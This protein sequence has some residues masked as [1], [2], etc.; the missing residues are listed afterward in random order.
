MERAHVD[1]HKARAGLRSEPRHAAVLRIDRIAEAALAQLRQLSPVR[2]EGP[3]SSAADLRL[4][5]FGTQAGRHPGAARWSRE[6]RGGS[7]GTQAG[8]DQFRDRAFARAPEIDLQNAREAK[9]IRE[10]QGDY[11]REM[12]NDPPQ[13]RFQ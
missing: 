5:R 4:P 9:F 1:G 12:G 3:T 2:L 8:R 11:E 6:R 10:N 7:A 13:L